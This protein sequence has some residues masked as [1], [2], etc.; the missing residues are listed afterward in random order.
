MIKYPALIR[1]R[2]EILLK[3][4]VEALAKKKHTEMSAMVRLLLWDIVTAHEKDAQLTAA[5]TDQRDQ[6][7]KGAVG[8]LS[9][10]A[11]EVKPDADPK[12]SGSRPVSSRIKKKP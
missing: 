11:P 9:K 6:I 10:A 3:R 2:C 8:A 7:V 1:V 5:L 4:K 12:L